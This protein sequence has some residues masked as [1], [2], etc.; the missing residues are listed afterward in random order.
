MLDISTFVPR[1]LIM[2]K[3]EERRCTCRRA[4]SFFPA[5]EFL[6]LFLPLTIRVCRFIK[7]DV[8]SKRR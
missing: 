7:S 8:Y 4:S 6:L 5:S 2:H 1:P 3:M